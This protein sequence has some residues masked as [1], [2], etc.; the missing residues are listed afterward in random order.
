MTTLN[1]QVRSHYRRAK[2]D[3]VCVRC[4]SPCDR[5]DRVCCAKCRT[6]AKSRRNPGPCAHCKTEADHRKRGLC[7]TCYRKDDIRSNYVSAQVAKPLDPSRPACHHC[8]ERNGHA[9]KR[10]LCTRCHGIK[11]VRDLYRVRAANKVEDMGPT[12]EELDALI[13]EQL[14]TMPNEPKDRSRLKILPLA[15]A[16]GR[17]LQARQRRI[18]SY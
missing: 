11:A 10:G 8:R 7:A 4:Q 6:P 2:A 5:P 16:R 13:A 15:V 17:G 3:G 12:M 14:P 9:C 1:L 18:D